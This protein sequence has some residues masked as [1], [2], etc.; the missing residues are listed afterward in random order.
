MVLYLMMKVDWITS[1]HI[2][3]LYFLKQKKSWSGSQSIRPT[4]HYIAHTA[5]YMLARLHRLFR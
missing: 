5:T 1:L 4:V 3:V 2:T